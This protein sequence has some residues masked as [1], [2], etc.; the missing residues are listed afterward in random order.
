MATKGRKLDEVWMH[1]ARNTSNPKNVKA[2][3]RYCNKD[4]QAIV[5]RMEKHAE[6]CKDKRRIVNNDM[7]IDAPIA[8][9]GTQEP[10]LSVAANAP[11]RSTDGPGPSTSTCSTNSKRQNESQPENAVQTQSYQQKQKEPPT[12]NRRLYKVL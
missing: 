5:S 4:M 2:R 12:K 1:F 9:D 3:C 7:Q 6:T 11:V 10:V 8:V